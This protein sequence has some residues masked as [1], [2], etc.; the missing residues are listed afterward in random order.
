M[1]PFFRRRGL[2]ILWTIRQ[3][4]ETSMFTWWL[5]PS[6][7]EKLTRSSPTTQRWLARS[8]V[9]HFHGHPVLE[10]IWN[11]FCKTKHVFRHDQLC[12]QPARYGVEKHGKTRCQLE[13]SLFVRPLTKACKKTSQFLRRPYNATISCNI[14]RY[15]NPLQ[16]NYFTASFILQ[17]F[18]IKHHES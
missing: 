4:L 16:K 17:C 1:Y 14:L 18:D 3:Q 6:W 12:A 5:R 9:G 7:L 2:S 13:S 15:P 10:R 11:L 8:D